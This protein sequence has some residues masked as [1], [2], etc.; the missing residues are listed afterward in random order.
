MKTFIR[1]SLINMAAMS[2]LTAAGTAYAEQPNSIDIPD[3][4]DQGQ[5]TAETY[6]NARSMSLPQVDTGGEPVDR[7]M[8]STI[9][10]EVMGQDFQEPV[11]DVKPKKKNRLFDGKANHG[12][13]SQDSG[14]ISITPT[15]VGTSSAYYTSSRINPTS[16]RTTWPWRT[17]GKLFFNIGTASYIC[18]ASVIS[19]RV[20]VT[21]GHC[22][23][24]GNGSSTGWYSNWRFVPAYDNGSAPFG[25][26]T[27]SRVIVS[28]EWYNGGGGV[29][30]SDDYAILVM[31]DQSISGVTRRIG[32]VTGWM[33]WLSN[34]MH[35]NHLTSI[36]YPANLDSGQIMHHV[37]AE[38]WK[39]Y[40]PNNYSIGSDMTGGSSGGAW[41]Q[42]FGVPAS[43][44]PAA[45]GTKG[46]FNRV[47]GVT[48]WGWTSP[49]PKE[50]GSAQFD[51]TFV[52]MWNS[53][54][55]TLSN[56]Q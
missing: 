9:D 11:I 43:G 2:L 36:G 30:N 38:T 27:A 22:V 52:N 55:A 4:Q 46:Y 37:N 32:E 35:P 15:A 16:S 42:N 21:A 39:Y 12:S 41:V 14:A 40:A 49:D 48:S 56:C 29:P 1:H 50:Q 26:W 24:S 17:N 10:G 44:Q 19:P 18:S 34:A 28:N 20:V 45:G 31:R 13:E 54:C 3:G 8:P 5:W 25:T 6:R 47:V 51:S 53:A 7:L 23:H 33:G